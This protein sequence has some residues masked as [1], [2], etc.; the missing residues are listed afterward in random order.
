VQ[1]SFDAVQYLGYLRARW[2]FIGVICAVACVLALILALLLP[3]RY[4]ATASMIIDPPAGND[5]RTVT[6][7]S[8]I[9]LESL[10]TYE[11]FAS[12]DTLF[13]KAADKFRLR[14]PGN[15]QSI[16]SL[17]RSVLKVSKVRDT[18]VLQISATLPDPKTAQA[19]A[20]FIAEETINLNRT[21]NRDADQDLIEDAKKPVQT[22]RA[23]LDKAQSA[24]S[25][26]D[27]RAPIE[28]LRWEVDSLIDLRSRVRRDLGETRANI[29][30]S[31]DRAALQ[32]RSERLE[33]QLQEL[34][35]EIDAKSKRVAQLIAHRQE[36]DAELRRSQITY[37]AASGRH[38]DLQAAA[39]LRGERLKIIDPGVVPDRPSFP[40]LGLSILVAF[41]AG[42]LGSITW[43][44]LTFRARRYE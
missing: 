36:L 29:A 12:S 44:T 1:D 9:Y 4:T 5:P 10:R 25:S 16:E 3:K 8:P 30:D 32:G 40:R 17:K 2:R 7:V 43:L 41:V 24:I 33:K 27:A 18:K 19:L 15:A 20:Q 38:R 23:D 39:I 22:A 21:L 14:E 34:E 31:N 26:F 28:A 35:R 13:Q 42:L 37:D 11:L 6:T